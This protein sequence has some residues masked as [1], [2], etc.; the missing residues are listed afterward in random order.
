MEDRQRGRIG[1]ALAFRDQREIMELRRWLVTA[2]RRAAVGELAA[3]I[4]HEVN[5]PMSFIQANLNLLHRHLGE[6]KAALAKHMSARDLPVELSYAGHLIGESLQGISRVVAIVREVRGFAHAGQGDH[7]LGD[8][9]ELLESAV[10][11][12]M[13]QL[14]RVAK[15]ER[16]FG[17]LPQISCSQQDLKQAV[18]NVILRAGRT[19]G[20]A[21]TIAL[22]TEA[23]DDEVVV[24]VEDDGESMRADDLADIFD[25]LHDARAG[26]FGSGLELAISY[27]IMRQHGG[28]MEIEA[29]PLGGTRV[30]LRIPLAQS[31]PGDPRTADDPSSP[32][33][34]EPCTTSS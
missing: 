15:V 34:D 26:S 31:E 11:L 4:A 3:G 1:Y 17:D 25:P 21:G 5:N 14:R 23:F 33:E 6:L 2:G 29:L 19:V 7:Q 30:R 18:L 16:F 10:R 28:D 22:V 13:P 8:V 9:N 32:S 12:A 20:G 24:C 27:E